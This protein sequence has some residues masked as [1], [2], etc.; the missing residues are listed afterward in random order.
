MATGAAPTAGAMPRGVPIVPTATTTTIISMPLGSSPMEP[1]ASR[2]PH[3]APTVPIRRCATVRYVMAY[4]SLAAPSAAATPRAAATRLRATTVAA[5]S[6]AILHV[7]TTAMS[8][9]SL[10]VTRA[11]SPIVA[12]V[13]PPAREA[14]A[15]APRARAAAS[16]AVRAVAV[17][18]TADPH[19]VAR[20]PRLRYS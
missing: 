10:A 6:R 14:T 16:S 3:A 5:I 19:A 9:T 8:P 12:R 20:Q 13:A 2:A 18:T 1:S 11:T 7:A 15:A 4:G 17:A